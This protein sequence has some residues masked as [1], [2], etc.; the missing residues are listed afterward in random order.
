[1]AN[2]NLTVFWNSQ[3]ESFFEIVESFFEIVESIFEKL[4]SFFEKLE[5]FFEIRWE[6]QNTVRFLLAAFKSSKNY[7]PQY[8]SHKSRIGWSL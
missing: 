3:S 1:M 2:R 5:S 7:Y 4:E 6:F 8:G